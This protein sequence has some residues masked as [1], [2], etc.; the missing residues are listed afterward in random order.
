M[1]AR[2]AD[3]R[4]IMENPLRRSG[5]T[6]TVIP[7]QSVAV[8][9]DGGRIA[10]A[11]NDHT[12]R[13]WD[14][15][16][17]SLLHTIDVGG[18]GPA[19]SVA[20]SP[21]GDRI[22]TGNDDGVLQV[23]TDDGAQKSSAP[24]KHDGA[25]NS[26][27]FSRDGRLI[28]TGSQDGTVRVWDPASATEKVH[29]PAVARG[30]RVRSVAFSPAADL[31]VAGGDDSTVRLF[32]THGQPVGAPF[33]GSTPV[34]SV[35]FSPVT[36]DRIVVGWLDGTIQVLDGRNLQSQGEPFTAHPN[37]IN[38]VAFN[39]GGDRIVSGGR[40]QYRT[41]VGCRIAQTNWDSADRSSRPRVG[42][43]VQPRRHAGSCRAASTVRCASGMWSPVFPFPPGRVLPFAR[44]RS[45]PTGTRWPRRAPTA[46]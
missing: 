14:S 5:D 38:S 36:G 1:A 23:W 45:V 43:G 44:S 4:K 10:S 27:A 39:P 34:M 29:I 11:S 46:P 2:S 3:T 12:V 37:A 42:G 7:I 8:S 17:G 30:M 20:F 9:K 16:S 19:W 15:D 22:A 32:D 21:T 18:Q 41:G 13:V 24:M 25:V 40:R 35:A 28:A 6:D 31:V 26:I 33:V